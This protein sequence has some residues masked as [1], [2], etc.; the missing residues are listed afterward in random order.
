MIFNQP[1]IVPKIL[2]YRPFNTGTDYVRPM[3]DQEVQEYLSTD[4]E[5]E[6]ELLTYWWNTITGLPGLLDSV[7]GTAPAV[8]QHARKPVE[9][10]FDVVTGR[11]RYTISGIVVPESRIRLG[12][13]RFSNQVQIQMRELTRQLVAKEIT[14]KQW[15]NRMLTAMKMEYKAAWLASI[16]GRSNYDRRQAALFGRAVAPQYRWLNNFLD[17]LNKKRQK[18]DGS[19]VMRAGMY[20]RAG[21]SI[22]QNNLL[23]V[24]MN[25]GFNWA[26]RI[27]GE[28]DNHCHSKKGR[29]GCVELA[30]K[31]WVRIADIVPIGDAACYSM[32]LCRYKFRK[33]AP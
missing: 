22:Y 2:P 24:A 18:L 20:A 29:Q 4:L 16:G 13:L 28:T 7:P 31:G 1:P 26:K 27:L 19:A 5:D 30:R 17:D 9:F 3:N 23:L 25:N 15:Y 14:R 21:N 33:S 8:V 10:Y 32:C 6:E 11:Y 12:M